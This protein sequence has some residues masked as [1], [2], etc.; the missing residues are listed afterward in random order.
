MC[1][2]QETD[3][4]KHSLLYQLQSGHESSFQTDTCLIHLFDN[5]KLQRSEGLFTGMVMVDLQKAFNKSTMDHQIIFQTLRY[6]GVKD[7]KLFVFY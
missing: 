5:I 7:V 6:I 3:R 2:Q 4:I 1:K